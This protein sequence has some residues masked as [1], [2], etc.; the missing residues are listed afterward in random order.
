MIASEVENL[1]KTAVA[2]VAPGQ[3]VD[4][5]LGP[6]K[7]PE[8]GDFATPIALSL[9]KKLGR[10]AFDIANALAAE[11]QTPDAKKLFSKVEVA[12]PGFLNLTLADDFWLAR[13]GEIL[14]R[15]DAFG[16]S[17]VG[18]NQ[19]VL[20]EYVS[21]N[22]TGPLHVG[23]ARNAAVADTVANLLVA[24]GHAVSREFYVNDLGVQMN[25]LGRS[26]WYRYA[27][28][29]GKA[30][31]PVSME[32]ELR[33]A[34]EPATKVDPKIGLELDLPQRIV[35]TFVVKKKDKNPPDPKP[36]LEKVAA[37]LQSPAAAAF[38]SGTKIAA[39]AVI[40]ELTPKAKR[41][42]ERFGGLYY[43]DYVKEV[44]AAFA[45]EHGD[46]WLAGA[47]DEEGI[48]EPAPEAIAAAREF[49]YPI[50][51]AEQK[52]TLEEYGVKFDR[53]FSERSL[54]EAG[55][56]DK[57]IDDLRARGEL[58]EAEGALWFA[59]KK[60]GDDKDRVVKKSDGSWTYTAPDIA[61]HR[62][63]LQRG[64]EM[65]INA[66]GADHHGYIPRMRAALEALGFDA[67][68]FHVILIQMVR[69]MR[70]GQ[71]VKMSK[72]SG[73]FV[74][75]QEVIDDV[76]P[77][78]ARYLMLIRSSDSG[79]DFDLD[80]AKK[81]TKD[82]PVFYVQYGHARVCSVFVQ[83]REKGATHH[84]ADFSKT[85]PDV[86]ALL[87]APPERDLMKR[88]ARFPE[89]IAEAARLRE[90]HRLATYLQEVVG[91]FHAYYSKKV[92]GAPEYRIVSEDERLTHA[93][94]ALAY[95]TRT[96]LGNGLAL[97]GVSAPEYMAAAPEEESA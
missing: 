43:G 26:V 28:A 47:V 69:L 89:V 44:A 61:Y 49:A 63:K 57:A 88:L 4:L 7:K 86:L 91:G 66:W 64:F 24:S 40:A 97:C 37:A 51:L 62:D 45:K 20:V 95:A 30:S 75:L 25:N 81:Q 78:A 15:K 56:V 55:L 50:L 42:Y 41:R 33:A 22:P 14:Q 17:D 76:G 67:S 90:P 11:L 38:I 82:N 70:G 8:F 27:E 84:A 34:I 71:E 18:K 48:P 1:L 53:F 77:D 94:L 59:S 29:A 35:F 68:R 32:P 23:H 80:L 5:A 16:R 65:L 46:K 72:R 12:R 87:T 73:S 31:F 21:A 6:P 9:A 52:K 60:R 54:H 92:N 83:A 2:K 74:T 36:A 58:F 13:L 10:D 96:V 85:P 39:E 79:L 19:K 3:T 93:R